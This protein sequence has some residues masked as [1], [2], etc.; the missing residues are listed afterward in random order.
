MLWIGGWMD[1]LSKTL[2]L[3]W[4]SLTGCDS[5]DKQFP[6]IWWSQKSAKAIWIRVSAAIPAPVAGGSVSASISAVNVSK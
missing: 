3:W 4:F 2:K 5:K 6:G 1:G